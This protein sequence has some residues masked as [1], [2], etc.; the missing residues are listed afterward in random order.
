MRKGIAEASVATIPFTWNTLQ[1]MEAEG[2]RY[3]QV[4]GLTTD[5]HYD[6]IDPNFLVLVP[7]MELPTDQDQKDIYEPV[8]SELLR[9]W[10]RHPETGVEILVASKG[11]I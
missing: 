8:K 5:K 10:A 3:V 1:K 2:Y 6:Y 9:E 11:L 4:K 7:M